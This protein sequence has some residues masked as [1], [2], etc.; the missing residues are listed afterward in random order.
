MNAG[1]RFL[2]LLPDVP[3]LIPVLHDV[4]HV[5]DQWCRV[6]FSG[7]LTLNLDWDVTLRLLIHGI[8][9][10]LGYDHEVS[11]AEAQRMRKAEREMKA[12]VRGVNAAGSRR[13]A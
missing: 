8:L 5:V 11:P 6:R 9:H 1:S 10:L 12:A 13:P 3:A 7:L 2:V 4:R